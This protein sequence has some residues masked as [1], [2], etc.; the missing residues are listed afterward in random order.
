MILLHECVPS[1]II[2][3]FSTYVTG[4]TEINHVSTKIANFNSSL[5]YLNLVTIQTNATK[6]FNTNGEFNKLSSTIYRNGI[7][8]SEMKILLKL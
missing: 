2:S 3:V 1:P 5:L 6:M 8:H 4:P 7:L